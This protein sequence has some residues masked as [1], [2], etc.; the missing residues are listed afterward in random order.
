MAV[1]CKRHRFHR[2]QLTL[3][4][5]TE[6]LTVGQPKYSKLLLH[7]DAQAVR[8]SNVLAGMSQRIAMSN[9]FALGRDVIAYLEGPDPDEKTLTDYGDRKI[10]WIEA[11]RDRFIDELMAA[12]KARFLA[13]IGARSRSP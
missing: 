11:V 5:R 6:R 13:R 9:L 12:Q 10:R 4:R 2:D 8:V 7:L 1:T 3:H